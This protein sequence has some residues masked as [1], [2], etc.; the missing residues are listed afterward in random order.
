M[1]DA[2]NCIQKGWTLIAAI[3][4]LT[5]FSCTHGG[6]FSFERF[7]G[8][9][10]WGGAWGGGYYST[11]VFFLRCIGALPCALGCL[12]HAPQTQIPIPATLFAYFV[13]VF[14][15]ERILHSPVVFGSLLHSGRRYLKHFE[16]KKKNVHKTK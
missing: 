7:N 12:F 13:L 6:C 1:C 10:V 9:L 8:V 5:A 16:K 3:L 2:L 14:T 15:S 4:F 11:P